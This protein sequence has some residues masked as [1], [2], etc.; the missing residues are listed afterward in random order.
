MKWSKAE[1]EARSVAVVGMS[2]RFPGASGADE[3]WELLRD[4]ADAT[5]ETP[6]DRYDIDSL[7]SPTGG[8]GT[9]SSRRAGY[10]EDM[11]DFDA[12]FFGMSPN[13]AVE[14]DPQHRLLMMTTWEALEDGGLRP[15]ALAG[16]RT[17][18][19]IGNH[20]ADFL[21]EQ[22]RQGPESINASAFHN[23]RS[24]LPGRLSWVFDFRGP[25]MTVDTA[26]SSSLTAIH[27]AV[28]SLRAREIPLAVVAGVNLALRSDDGI[29][30]TQAGT[31]AGDGRSKFGDADA[32]GYAPSDGVGVVILK[33]LADARADGDRIRAVIR[34]SALSNDGRSGGGLLTPSLTGQTDVLRWA[35]EDAGVPPSDV[36]FVEAH[37]TGSP[38]LDPL[39]FTALGTVL[40]EGRPAERPCYIGSVKTNIGH[41]EAAGSMAGLFKTILC[42]ENGQ[43]PASLNL[44]TP[45][46]NVAWDELPLEVPTKLLNLPD[47]GRPALAG[48][49][50]QGA[51]CLNAH[52]VVAQADASSE[53][54]G[55]ALLRRS[56][57][58]SRARILAL[59]A[60]SPA[61]LEALARAY[62]DY[63]GPDGKGSGFAM[64]DICYSA[65]SRRQHHAHR[66]TVIGSSHKEMIAALESFLSGGTPTEQRKPVR[67]LAA[68][69]EQYESG[70]DVD[71]D[72][73]FGGHCRF[74]PV[75]M[76]PWQTK[77]YWPG[78]RAAID[79]GDDLAAAVLREHAR[80]SDTDFPDNSLLSDIG[81][82]SLARLQITVKLA[83]DH[84]YDVDTVELAELR[85]VG[86][87]RSWLHTLEAQAV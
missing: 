25:S 26:C 31:L 54:T 4:E 33:P 10:V 56:L 82:D 15:D 7:Y 32:D 50:G 35:Y 30:M 21:E 85:T 43:I 34:G 53:G 19:F 16:S 13:E 41:A 36:D 48:V 71:W 49:T 66:L 64:R 68:A 62:V 11:A 81:I 75:P 70:G 42:L 47:R 40:G 39:E 63:L 6:S 74:V 3:L 65:A 78:E 73:L 77:R 9:I 20:R 58:S 84:N 76:Y 55:T 72:K 67:S 60:V 14:L 79:D 23:F 45:N 59:S 61:A 86:D 2:C 27:A 22:F 83:S 52:L 37:G 12:E 5:S 18:V 80:I 8:V 38:M 29:M 57:L 44:N 46:P 24:L 87:L 69:A 28:Q 51:S 17:G 1:I